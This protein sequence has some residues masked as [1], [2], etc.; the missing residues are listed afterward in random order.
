[1]PSAASCGSRVDTGPCEGT[2]HFP[3][4]EGTGRSGQGAWQCKAPPSYFH[5]HRAQH[6]VSA[7]TK[8][9]ST[10]LKR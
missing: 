2:Q 3:E 7:D 5:V 6:Q 8:F 9:P 10:T 4:E 1:M